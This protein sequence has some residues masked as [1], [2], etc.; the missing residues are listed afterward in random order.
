MKPYSTLTV[1]GNARRLRALATNVLTHY[2]LDVAHLRLVTNDM[3]GIFRIHTIDGSK[4]ILH[5]NLP[6]GGHSLDHVAA[7]MD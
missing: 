3:N 7:E 5:V 6:E 4:F 2:E 1:R